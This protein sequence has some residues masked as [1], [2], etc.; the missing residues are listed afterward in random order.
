MDNIH[1]SALRIQLRRQLGGYRLSGQSTV[2]RPRPHQD[3]CVRHVRSVVVFV[4]SPVAFFC[5]CLL[6]VV[7]RVDQCAARVEPV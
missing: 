7:A 3:R 6:M 2:S 1:H 5:A 4:R